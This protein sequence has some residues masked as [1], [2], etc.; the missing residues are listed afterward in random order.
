VVQERE[1]RD[2]KDGLVIMDE[3]E[4]YRAQWAAVDKIDRAVDRVEHPIGVL[5]AGGSLFLAQETDVGIPVEQ[6]VPDEALDVQVDIGHDVAIA[7]G[8]NAGW[9]MVDRV[10]DGD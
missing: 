1:G 4:G 7:L 6:Q 5:V 8:A 3:G 9:L 10:L 2:A